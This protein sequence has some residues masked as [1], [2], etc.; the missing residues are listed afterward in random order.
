VQAQH[1]GAKM[2]RGERRDVGPDPGTEAIA[3][4]VRDGH[5][6]RIERVMGDER[7]R[8]QLDLDNAGFARRPAPPRVISSQ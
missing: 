5:L 2:Q 8:T 3:G 6:D 1:R 4:R 7:E